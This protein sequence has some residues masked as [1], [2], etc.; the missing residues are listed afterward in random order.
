[1]LAT[2]RMHP[3]QQTHGWLV[4]SVAEH[5]LAVRALQARVRLAALALASAV[6]LVRSVAWMLVGRVW[7]TFG[8]AM[9]A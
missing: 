1:V 4:E 2:H 3:V 8:G 6:V 7:L 9:C 5:G